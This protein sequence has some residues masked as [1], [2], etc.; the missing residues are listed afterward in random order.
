VAGHGTAVEAGEET[1]KPGKNANA[2]SAKVGGRTAKRG[3]DEVE[4]RVGEV[5][6]ATSSTLL[7]QRLSGAGSPRLVRGWSRLVFEASLS[8][9]SYSASSSSV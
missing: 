1:G 5:S 9:R 7:L 8:C 2:E 4:T 6:L 3:S